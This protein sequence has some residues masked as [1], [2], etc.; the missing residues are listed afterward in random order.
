[1]KFM[2]SIEGKPA[3]F[4][5]YQIVYAPRGDRKG[6]PVPIKL[7][8]SREQI[9]REQDASNWYRNAE[10]MSLSDYGYFCVETP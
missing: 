2:H 9:K 4:N 10:K 3:Y 7:A 5:G 1:M 8:D 6:R